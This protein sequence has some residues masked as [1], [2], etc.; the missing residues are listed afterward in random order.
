[1]IKRACLL[2]PSNRNTAKSAAVYQWQSYYLTGFGSEDNGNPMTYIR[3]LEDINY[4]PMPAYGHTVTVPSQHRHG[5]PHQLRQPQATPDGSGKTFTN[6]QCY[7][8]QSL[9][10]YLQGNPLQGYIRMP[11]GYTGDV[12]LLQATPRGL[13]TSTLM[14]LSSTRLPIPLCLRFNRATTTCLPSVTTSPRIDGS[15][16]LP[17]DGSSTFDAHRDQQV[18]K[19]S[20][21]ASGRERVGRERV[22]VEPSQVNWS[23]FREISHS[24]RVML[25]LDITKT[26]VAEGRIFP[27]TSAKRGRR[28]PR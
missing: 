28:H 21:A 7:L 11:I 18:V 4:A 26:E 27:S 17:G 16:A 23:A 9:F 13:P 22:P 14:T 20:K 10:T 15:V 8:F 19:P 3:H 5:Q 25:Q 6:T 12:Y 24:R 1:M 2:C